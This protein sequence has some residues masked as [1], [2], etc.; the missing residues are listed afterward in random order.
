[1]NRPK[2]DVRSELH[3]CLVCGRIYS[4]YV[5][6]TPQGR[7]L[8]CAVMDPDGQRVQDERRPLVACKKHSVDQ[9]ETALASHYPGKY[10]EED[11]DED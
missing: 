7:F 4:L 1:M 8:D 10:Q 3:G 2:K 5:S 9:V 11:E 6:Y